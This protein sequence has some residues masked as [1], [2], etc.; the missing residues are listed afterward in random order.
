[1]AA[2]AHEAETVVSDAQMK[3]LAILW[4]LTRHRRPGRS[5]RRR[6]AAFSR[7][8][9]A[10]GGELVL[11]GSQQVF[12][13]AGT[14]G[15]EQ[16][17]AANDQTLVWI[18]WRRHFG[19]IA[20]VE[21]RQLKCRPRQGSDGRRTQR[22][23]PVEPGGPSTASMRASVIMPR[24]PTRTTWSSAKRCLSLLT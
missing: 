19:E 16:R 5:G 10:A 11:G 14:F 15:G 2:V 7:V 23:D 12:A 24:S 18:I 8:T 6:A 3:C 13:F 17:I 1:M 21:Q 9:P 22:G 4:R 20:F